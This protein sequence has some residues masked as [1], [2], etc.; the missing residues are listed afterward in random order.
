[1]KGDNQMD[2][3][4]LENLVKEYRQ[5]YDAIPK[6]ALE[7][8]LR[9]TITTMQ[10]LAKGHPISPAQLA[11]IWEM[12][13]D[14]VRAI[15]EQAEKNG[16]VE[17]D[18]QGNLVGAMLSLNSTNHKVIMDGKHLFAWCAYDAIY[19]SG[20]VGKPAQISS[21]DP[22]TGE[23]IRVSLT[24]KGVEQVEPESVVV[25]VVGPKED[26]RAGP[27]SSRCTQML[28]F[29]S[30]ESAELWRQNRVGV[31]ILTMEEVFKVVEEFQIEPA[32][33]LGLV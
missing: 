24:P 1:M 28:F 4:T 8:D 32:K 5:T 25:S 15:L 33:R 10:A 19:A 21:K 22:V 9:V 7:L 30:R 18:G 14:Q 12:P 31:Y 20:V 13:F 6:E 27:E 26:S 3:Y 2:Q 16:Q 17:I 23:M 29:R 11:D